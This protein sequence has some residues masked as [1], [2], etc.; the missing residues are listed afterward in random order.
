MKNKK[1]WKQLS[2][3]MLAMVMV[4]SATG[5]GENNEK[6]NDATESNQASKPVAES[7]EEVDEF[8]WL[9]RDGSLNSLPIVAEGTEKTLSI[10]V[11]QSSQLGEY[12]DKYAYHF[13]QEIM[14]INLDVTVITEPEQVHMAFA[15]GELPDLIL[16]APLSTLEI[17]RYGS[18][19]MLLD[20]A[21]YINETYMPNLTA[22][23]DANPSFKVTNSKGQV[24]SL[25]FYRSSED[26]TI[27]KAFFINYDW[28]EQ[29]NLEVPTTLDQFTEV[30]RAF[31]T[32]GDDI[33][34]ISG[35]W[36][37]QNPFGL[38]MNAY[39]YNS[40]Y[41]QN[42]GLDITL[43]DGEVVL[44]VADRERFGEVITYMAEA[45][46][47][48]LIHP[49]F[50]T[51]DIDSMKALDQSGKTG[52]LAHAP[53]GLA[54]EEVG[55]SF[56]AMAPLTSEYRE[57][58]CAPGTVDPRLGG[59]IITSDCEEVELALTFLDWF[60]QTADK[61]DDNVFRLLA[62]G[63]PVAGSPYETIN[64]I[65]W[66]TV[67]YDEKG[68]AEFSGFGEW[69][70]SWDYWCNDIA[71][72]T[73]ST[74]GTSLDNSKV[75]D[76]TSRITPVMLDVES[77]YSASESAVVRKDPNISAAD[78]YTTSCY[79]VIYPHWSDERY[80]ANV[81]LSEE[82][83]EKVSKLKAAIEEYAVTEIAK[84]VTGTRSLSEL[85]AYF[86]EL[87]RLGA[88]EYVKIYAD[89]YEAVK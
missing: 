84:F 74:I 36:E 10:M 68:N 83:T 29:L 7:K 11:Q 50:F 63:G 80:P 26:P 65:S 25:G 82:E 16:G 17:D 66:E 24:F 56:W 38:V 1:I 72:W 22:L 58:P 77:K 75:S 53:Y 60:Y 81:F 64:G 88:Q 41:A 67:T 43:R 59:A 48:G 9:N 89:Y 70:S 55:E 71:L 5:C 40:V 61:E 51:M 13:I 6:P 87:D 27:G 39:G 78:K 37:Y 69:E 20:F 18:E 86:D 8:A 23:F 54:G 76:I 79:M 49:D 30:M 46:E 85:D 34:P 31:K 73:L 19:G 35:T 52:Y 14:N 12:E 47:E 32:L 3:A 2:A 62:A 28:L 33:V 21:P 15:S 4:C 45:Y 44:P 57:T 42:N